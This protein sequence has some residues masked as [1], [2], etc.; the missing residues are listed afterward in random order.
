MIGMHRVYYSQVERGLHNLSVA[1]LHKIAQGL[2]LSASDL[3]RKA[4]L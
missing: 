3:L 1:S 4:G 2:E